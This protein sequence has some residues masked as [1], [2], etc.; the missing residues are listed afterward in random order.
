[1]LLGGV[2]FPINSPY[3][4]LVTNCGFVFALIVMFVILLFSF[5]LCHTF[6]SAIFALAEL[7]L[8]S[9]D[10]K[11]I[12]FFFSFVAQLKWPL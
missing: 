6:A 9:D 2:Y 4:L 10:L 11:F 12:C 3:R 7:W 5:S 8:L 1:M